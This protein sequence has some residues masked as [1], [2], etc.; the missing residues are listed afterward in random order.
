[1]FVRINITRPAS[2]H[3]QL[4]DLGDQANVLSPSGFVLPLRAVDAKGGQ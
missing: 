3:P 4:P 2:A 1:M